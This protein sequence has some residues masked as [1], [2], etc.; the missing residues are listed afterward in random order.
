MTWRQRCASTLN[1]DLATWTGRCRTARALPNRTSYWASR[2]FDHHPFGNRCLRR[3]AMRCY[4]NPSLHPSEL[5]PERTLITGL[6]FPWEE[7]SGG[8]HR[9]GYTKYT[10]R[11]AG[12][13]PRYS[14]PSFLVWHSASRFSCTICKSVVRLNYQALSLGDA[15]F[16]LASLMKTSDGLNR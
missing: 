13:K 16:S 11:R 9:K 4:K 1:A 8:C 3:R 7:T 12:I 2:L 5:A 6:Q 15:V 14:K 10:N